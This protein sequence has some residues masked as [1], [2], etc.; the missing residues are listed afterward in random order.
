MFPVFGDVRLCR[1]VNMSWLLRPPHYPAVWRH[2]RLP[3]WWTQL[4]R[5]VP[6]RHALP[7]DTSR[8]NNCVKLS[9][10]GYECDIAVLMTQWMSL[11]VNWLNHTC[12]NQAPVRQRSTCCVL[13]VG[14]DWIARVHNRIQLPPSYQCRLCSCVIISPIASYTL[15]FQPVCCNVVHGA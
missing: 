11:A 6:W 15:R 5:W 4:P 3:H 14:G 12:C 2:R 8:R 9:F 1:A 13:I 10:V 7:F